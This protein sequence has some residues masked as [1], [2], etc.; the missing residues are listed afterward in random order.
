MDTDADVGVGPSYTKNGTGA[1]GEDTSH[2][3]P[4]LSSHG[5]VP[6]WE[7]SS[8]TYE[9]LCRDMAGPL[10]DFTEHR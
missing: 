9:Q 6:Y 5:Q 10:I 3:A 2:G 1:F 8:M 4:G 7:G